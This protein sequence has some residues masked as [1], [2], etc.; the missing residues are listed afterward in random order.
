MKE[1]LIVS[2]IIGLAACW[3]M[4]LF[5][6]IG[7]IEWLQVHAPS[8]VLAELF[9]CYFCMCWWTCLALSFSFSIF[10]EEPYFIL[11]SICATPIARYLI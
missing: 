1:F 6:K 7:L 4:L 9:E 10:A 11:C 3:M 2:I 5:Q 8:K